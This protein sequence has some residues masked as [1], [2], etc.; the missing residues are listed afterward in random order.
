MPGHGQLAAFG[1][2][3]LPKRCIE[4]LSYENDV[5]LDPFSGSGT[6]L[7]AAK[8]LGFNFIGTEL[9]ENYVSIAKQRLKTL[10]N[11]IEKFL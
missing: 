2:I 6:T 10:D 4:L 8:E 5:V 9:D 7:L 11:P 3:E 1:S